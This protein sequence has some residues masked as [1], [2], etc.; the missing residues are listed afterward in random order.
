MLAAFGACSVIVVAITK[1]LDR[2]KGRKV[3]FGVQGQVE[4]VEGFST[5][6]V[7]QV[8][9]AVASGQLE[10]RVAVASQD[11]VCWQAISTRLVT[12]RLGDQR[13]GGDVSRSASSFL[14]AA[15]DRAQEPRDRLNS[16]VR[17]SPA[18][19]LRFGPL[20]WIVRGI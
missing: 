12:A 3:T 4:S 6:E 13:A 10:C 18:C 15:R 1:F 16:A 7:I 11:L 9:D 14:C 20:A 5:K 8:L 17:V 19:L 2:H